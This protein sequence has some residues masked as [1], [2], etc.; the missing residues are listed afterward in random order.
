MIGCTTQSQVPQPNAVWGRDVY[1][2]DRRY[3]GR[4]EYLLNHRRLA[5]HHHA[6]VQNCRVSVWTVSRDWP[7]E[8]KPGKKTDSSRVQA[9]ETYSITSSTSR[10]LLPRPDG[11]VHRL[12]RLQKQKCH[13]MPRTLDQRPHACEHV[14]R[15]QFAHRPLKN[16]AREAP[17]R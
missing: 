9:P 16:R 11:L 12:H 17:S 3:G 5:S 13:T 7:T 10:K 8:I 14:A 15:D 1:A 2:D 4:S 6:P